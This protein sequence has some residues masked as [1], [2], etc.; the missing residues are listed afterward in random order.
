MAKLWT[1][2][3]IKHLQRIIEQYGRGAEYNKQKIAYEFAK[4][5]PNRTFEGIRAK[6]KELRQSKQ[7]TMDLTEDAQEES[8]QAAEHFKLQAMIESA[9]ARIIDN[10]VPKSGLELA[11]EIFRQAG[12]RGKI[13]LELGE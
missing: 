1:S 4:A 13:T 9:V 6:M 10:A 5:Y 3:E 8:L 2:L 11:V 12:L 7:Y